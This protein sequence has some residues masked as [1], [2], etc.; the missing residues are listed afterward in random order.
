MVSIL[1][2]GMFIQMAFMPMLS[3]L[4]PIVCGGI[5][6]SV[7]LAYLGDSLTILHI[8]AGE[9]T[10]PDIGV[11][12]MAVIIITIIAGM[13]LAMVLGT[14]ITIGNLHITTTVWQ[15]ARMVTIL[16]VL[17]YLRVRVCRV[18]AYRHEPAPDGW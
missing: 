16:V 5:G 15:L 8:G 3:L 9:A 18:R 10:I 1:G 6:V 14:D 17:L 13:T 4:I 12:G 11:D 7:H 2:I